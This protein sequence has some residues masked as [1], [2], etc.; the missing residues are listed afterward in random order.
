MEEI[1][2]L[3]FDLVL[4]GGIRYRV[5]CSREDMDDLIDY[6]GEESINDVEE[7]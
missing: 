6:I 3:E 4:K 1:I 5:I 7:L 2:C